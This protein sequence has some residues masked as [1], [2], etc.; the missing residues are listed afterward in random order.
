VTTPAAP[1][2]DSL[3]RHR[4][5][6]D[7]LTA[8]L[9]AVVNYLESDLETARLEGRRL[10]ANTAATAELELRVARVEA[11]T[12]KLRRTLCEPGY[13][14]WSDG[15]PA[16][17]LADN[18]DHSKHADVL[19]RQ[20]TCVNCSITWEGVRAPVRCPNCNG[21]LLSIAPVGR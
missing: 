18:A 20:T 3:E 15:T 1:A 21:P 14:G 8:T 13:L 19:E 12:E 6:L 10:D 2:G 7:R 11:L 9:A 4:D 5:E 16:D 17:E